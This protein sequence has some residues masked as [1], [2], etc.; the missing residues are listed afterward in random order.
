MVI[1]QIPGNFK[2]INGLEGY[3]ISMYTLPEY[4][5]KGIA[6]GILDKLLKKGEELGLGK[7]YLHASN[8][9]ISLYKQNGF[10]ETDMPVLEK[11]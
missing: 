7:L 8:D 5:K 11:Y 2:L 3:I 1:Q 4:R 6:G 10:I 9:G